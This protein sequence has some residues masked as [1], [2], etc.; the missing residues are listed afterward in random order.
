MQY[1]H[2]NAVTTMRLKKR[3]TPYCDN[4]YRENCEVRFLRHR[5]D[6][7]YLAPFF[8]YP[9]VLVKLSPLTN[10]C[11]SLTQ[12]FSVISRTIAV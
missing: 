12:S 9:A 7:T 4:Y 11:L 5:V 3:A 8:S 2:F 10:G 6:T 1:I